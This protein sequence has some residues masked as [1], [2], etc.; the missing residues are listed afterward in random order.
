[1]PSGALS[2]EWAESRA[3]NN[4]SKVREKRMTAEKVLKTPR[5][6]FKNEIELLSKGHMAPRAV[7]ARHPYPCPLSIVMT[8][9]LKTASEKNETRAIIKT[10]FFM[11]FH[12]NI[13]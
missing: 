5:W 13:L 2:K 12:Y 4:A 8:K 10:A 6:K 1:M 9:T 11:C 7:S 3:P